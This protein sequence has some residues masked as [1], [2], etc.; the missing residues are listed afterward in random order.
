MEFP[1]N[2][3]WVQLQAVSDA[4]TESGLPPDTG[5]EEPETVCK[6]M[7][8]GIKGIIFDFDGTIFDNAYIAMRL[9]AA[10]PIDILPVYGERLVRSRFAGQDF[11]SPEIYHREFFN[12]L[13]KVCLSSPKRMRSWYFDR[14]MP[15]MIRVLKKHFKPRQGIAEV[16]RR[17]Q[18]QESSLQLAIYS[19]YPFLKERMTSLGLFPSEKIL[20]YGPDSFGAQKPAVRPFLQIA[21]DLRLPPGEILVIGDR[22]ETDGLGAFNAGMHFF[23]LETG[24]RRYYRLDPN[25]RRPEEESHGPT[26]LMYAGAWDELIRL[27]LER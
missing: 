17:V 6:R 11:S 24:H 18:S 5:Y 15:R 2:V 25:R 22:E 16:L 27:L 9:I 8:R 19:D 26:L 20:L 10:C 1:A 23:C 14:Y 12:E 21:G 3:K 7:L 4:D 13:G